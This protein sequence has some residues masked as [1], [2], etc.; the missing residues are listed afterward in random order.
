MT[1][2]LGSPNP[3][4]GAKPDGWASPAATV[5]LFL[6]SGGDERIAA[7]PVTGLT[8]YGTKSLP[9]EDEIWFSSS[10]ASTIDPRGFAAAAEMVSQLVGMRTG[11]GAHVKSWFDQLRRRLVDCFGIPGSEAVLTSSGTEAEFAVL[12]VARALLQRPLTNIVVAPTE[13]GRGVMMA[14]AGKHFLP[15]SCHGGPVGAGTLVAGF[16]AS[17]ETQG[18]AIRDE[19]GF[20]REV[21]D[22]D[23]DAATLVAQALAA[24]RD[25]ILHVL[26]SSKTGLSGVTR[27]TAR[28]LAQQA[29]GR[30]AV[31]VDACQLRCQPEQLQKDLESGFMVMITGS[32]FSGG[33]PFSGALF[34]SP[35]TIERLQ[36]KRHIP[37]GLSD[38]SARLDWPDVLRGEFAGDLAT[39]VNLGLGLRWEA[40]LAAIEPYFDLADALRQQILTWF[41]GSVHRRVT[42]RP[43][44]RLIP[45]E[46]SRGKTIIP[47][48]TRGAFATLEGTA[49]LYAALGAPDAPAHAPAKLAKACHVGQPVQVG[50]RAAL[51]ICASMPMVLDIAERIMQ[52]DRIEAAVAPVLEDL[53]LL[54]E[55]WD[56]LARA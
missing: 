12:S 55:K 3:A 51:R 52:G 48:E 1:R 14:A 5:A 41:A 18:I 7:D 9:A 4:S 46:P 37:Q 31:V 39:P 40:A 43:H 53:D 27:D 20:P 45:A 56:C 2:A 22:I 49:S 28:A 17:V 21:A 34:L 16:D 15:S 42:A 26:D 54:F 47:I 29:R 6:S 8:R 33:P 25:V 23:R 30:I 35:S 38:Y 19:A 10:T 50:E 32:K 24:G 36:G 11:G 13:T 44:L